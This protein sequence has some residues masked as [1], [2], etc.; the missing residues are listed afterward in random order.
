MSIRTAAH[1]CP[2]ELRFATLDLAGEIAYFQSDSAS[3]PGQVNVTAYDLTD[4][5]ICCFCTGAEFGRR[6]WHVGLIADAWA[7]TPER[8]A[9]ALV[10]GLPTLAE[11][12]TVGRMARAR[13]DAWGAAS[14]LVSPLDRAVL[15][16][17]RREWR[18]RAAT[19][20]LAPLVTFP[21]AHQRL[22]A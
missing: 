5:A 11:V 9:A 16:A 10:A 12:E 13:V 22:V 21:V 17:A 14:A 1:H 2:T 8:A 19:P 18:K 3:A 6:C 7:A 20:A 4:G 15:D